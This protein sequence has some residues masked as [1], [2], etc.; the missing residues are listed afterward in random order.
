MPSTAT[1]RSGDPNLGTFTDAV[2]LRMFGET[3]A[4]LDEL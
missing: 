2:V 4:S 1:K 3:P